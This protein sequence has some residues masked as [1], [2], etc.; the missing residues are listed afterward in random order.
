[1]RH[2]TELQMAERHVR[3]GEVN[4]ARQGQLIEQLRIDG[5]DTREAEELLAEFEAIFTEHKKH[6][7]RIRAAQKS[8][9]KS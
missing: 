7:E 9:I 1:M 5:H 6:L 2:E 4:V 8:G 3:Q